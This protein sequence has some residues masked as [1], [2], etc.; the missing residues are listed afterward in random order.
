M[1]P[2]RER[3]TITFEDLPDEYGRPMAYRV[4]RLLKHALR[5]LNLRCLD[6]RSQKPQDDADAT[7]EAQDD[8]NPNPEA[9]EK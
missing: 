8:Q 6:Y 4:R 3:W 1:K 2:A 9:L 5:S 7:P